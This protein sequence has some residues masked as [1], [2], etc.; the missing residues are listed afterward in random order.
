[1]FGLLVSFDCL[2]L[3]VFG[4]GILLACFGFKVCVMFAGWMIVTAF[5]L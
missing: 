3:V 1:M 5:V 4:L 2:S